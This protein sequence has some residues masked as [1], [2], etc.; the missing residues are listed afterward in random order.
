MNRR[1]L[2]TSSAGVSYTWE[3]RA[4]GGY[5][6]RGYQDVQPI[7]DRNVDMA[8]HNNGY[9]GDKTFRRV[10]SIPMHL[11]YQWAQEEGWNAFD[12]EHADKLAQKLNDLDF[13]KLRTAPGRVSAKGGVLR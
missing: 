7:L 4:D 9:S 5:E 1:H 12:P 11:I 13:W 8:N 6:V 2:Y 3:D 10:G